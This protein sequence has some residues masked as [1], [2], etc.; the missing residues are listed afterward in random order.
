MPAASAFQVLWL[1]VCTIY[2]Q[3]IQCYLV[4]SMG[5]AFS[6]VHNLPVLATSVDMEKAPGKGWTLG[7]FSQV[8]LSPF[9]G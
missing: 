1:Q 3:G 6:P 4:F 7:I 9:Q 5:D 8:V 2:A